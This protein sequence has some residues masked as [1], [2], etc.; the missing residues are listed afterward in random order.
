[1]TAIPFPSGPLIDPQQPGEVSSPW[2]Y[3]FMALL[4][5]EAADA[6]ILGQITSSI[7]VSG[8][9]KLPGGYIRQW[10]SATTLA[11]GGVAIGFPIAFPTAALNFQATIASAAAPVRLTI[12]SDAPTLVAVNVWAGDSNTGAGVAGVGFFWEAIG[13]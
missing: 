6:A 1:M 8:Y 2:R 12:A 11:G 7:G 10:G 3:F 9:Q 5:A 13:E 4:R